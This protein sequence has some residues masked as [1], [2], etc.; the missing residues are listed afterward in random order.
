MS[1]IPGAVKVTGFIGPTDDTDIYPTID[2]L[3]G[4]DGLRSVA[5]NTERDAIS[6]LRRRH[7]MEVFTRDSG[8]K[9]RLAADLTTWNEI[10][11]TVGPGT[12]NTIAKF[13][14]NTTEIGDSI[15]TDNGTT[16][17]IGTGFSFNNTSKLFSLGGKL[18]IINTSE[19][20]RIGYDS[21]NYYSCNISSSGITTFNAVG[22][23]AGFVF[24]N[25]I[26]VTSVNYT[27]T[28]A[29]S[30]FYGYL[31][32]GT[33][34][35][36][37]CTGFGW[38]S[39]LSN[40]S[41]QHNSAFGLQ[42]LRLNTSGSENSAFGTFAL[43]GNTTGYFNSSFGTYSLTINTT[44]HD[45]CAFGYYSLGTNLTGYYNSGFG[46][47]S[48]HM[49]TSGYSNTAIGID[50]LH[51]VATGYENTSIGAFSA[52]SNTGNK[53]VTIGFKAGY[54]QTSTSNALLIDNQDRGNSSNELT[55]ALIYGIFDVNA[56]S[57]MLRFNAKTINMSYLPTSASG[58][59]T[60]DLWNNLGIINIV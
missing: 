8:K 2:P 5:N 39:L 41:G 24:S 36:L 17:T 59:T 7:G 57:Q 6:T 48:A 49:I 58:L 50:S 20:Y 4:I 10:L 13:T 11:L 52:Y 32:G 37:Y 42:A 38:A 47:G 45:N 35:G 15:I 18:D 46:V 1:D 55:R 21:S 53:N 56:T 44:G 29:T 40:T 26:N 16:V 54:Y 12:I 34:T 30:Q 23:S 14:P 22:A 51:E 27:N 43:D 28:G 19:Q 9:W 25:N 60:G 31:S 33:S 3:Y